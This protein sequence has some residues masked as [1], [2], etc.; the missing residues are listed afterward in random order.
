MIVP[1]RFDSD[2]ATKAIVVNSVGERPAATASGE[3][4]TL[5][6]SGGALGSPTLRVE[7]RIGR[8]SLGNDWAKR[9]KSVEDGGELTHEQTT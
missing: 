7:P 5:K 9:R 8:T 4:D 3:V 1:G 6:L 2:G